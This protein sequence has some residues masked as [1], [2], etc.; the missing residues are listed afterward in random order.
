MARGGVYVITTRKPHAL[1]GLWLLGRHIGYVGLTNS[2]ARRKKQHLEGDRRYNVSAKD[3]ADL[4]PRFRPL[5]PLPDW[6]WLLELVESIAI[7]LLCPVYNVEK[8]PPWNL[9]KIQPSTA[10]RQRWT[11]DQ[12][13]FTARVAAFA[14]RML[15]WVL[16]AVAAWLVWG[17]TR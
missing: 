7:A 2:Y 16:V 3:W 15:L 1:L 4:A 11:R 6:R 10:K 8:Q 13:G 17:W 14:L 5:V 12:F 9:R